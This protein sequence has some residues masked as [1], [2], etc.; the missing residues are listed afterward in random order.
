MF[1]HILIPTDGSE[2][3][4]MAIA[5]GVKFA[6]E[7]N[8]RIT[9]ITVTMP[10][11]FFAL[12]ATMLVDSMDLYAADTKAMAARNLQVLKDA[13]QAAGVECA[14]VHRVSEHPYEE[15]VKAAHEASCDVIFMASHGRRGIQ[16]LIMG[17]ETHKVLTHTKIPV[18][19]FR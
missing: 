5:Q 11:H 10:Y 15:I 9:G 6:R 16:A 4:N 3:S 2:L 18:L 12:E 7:I 8:A 17:G 14:T 1:K 13:A 19:V